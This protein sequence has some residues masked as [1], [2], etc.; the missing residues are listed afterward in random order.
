MGVGATTKTRSRIVTRGAGAKPA[1]R[2]LAIA[3]G[4]GHWAQLCM[5]RP[6]FAGY[7]VRFATTIAGLAEKSGAASSDLLSDCNRN[8]RWRSVLT[9]MQVLALLMRHRPDVVVTTG[10]LPGLIAIAL[11]KRLGARTIWIDSIANAE[12]MSMA[13]SR[14]R[15]YADLWVSQWPHVAAAS[16]AKFHGALL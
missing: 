16:G 15:K 11:A 13:G 10:A 12:E 2:L 1:S 7:D 5:L 14:A 6:A 3:S 9:A 8:Q 4:G